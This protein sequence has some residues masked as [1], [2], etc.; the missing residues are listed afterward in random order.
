VSI[1]DSDIGP[2]YQ[3]GAETPVNFITYGGPDDARVPARNVLIDNSYIH[4]F[5]R[6][7]IADH[8]ECIQIAG[9]DGITIRRT[10][11]QRCDI[12]ALYFTQWAGPDPP[13]NIL[14][15][16]NWFDDS[17][18]D[19]Q[20]GGTTY[21]VWFSDNMERF[22]NIT[23]R[24]NT[25]KQSLAMGL[26]PKLGVRFVGNIAPLPQFGCLEDVTYAY[27]VWNGA[28]CSPTDLNAA[29]TFVD[30]PAFDLHLAPGSAALD[31]GDPADRP[32][33]D[34]DGDTR[35]QDGPPDAGADETG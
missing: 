2:A 35:P 31:A 16:N 14:I 5:R 12:F 29:A 28:R 8:M 30:E 32:A 33:D 3:P 34:I 22:E 21:T 11:F 9:G 24:Y 25:A 4:D 17:T 27:N 6:G 23:V 20:P 7:T 13:K 18:T 1:L 15:E 26:N 19:G 10:K